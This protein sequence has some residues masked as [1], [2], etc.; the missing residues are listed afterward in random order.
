[1]KG[2][3]ALFA[4]L[5]LLIL[6][7]LAILGMHSGWIPG[8]S[9]RPTDVRIY[10]ETCLLQTLNEGLVTIGQGERGG[11]MLAAPWGNVTFGRTDPA[12]F[13]KL[14]G[15]YIDSNLHECID[16]SDFTAKISAESP[17]TR[18]ILTEG[19]VEAKLSYPVTVVRGNSTE[20]IE[21]YRAKLPFRALYMIETAN[22]IISGR[23]YDMTY[24]D[25]IAANTTIH[26][27]QAGQA[28]VLDDGTWK[29]AFA[30][31]Y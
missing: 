7:A 8:F 3:I 24:L 5:G 20:K 31:K 19:A 14:L 11:E 4:V 29:F 23:H 10:V 12:T 27:Y 30:V 15:E 28:V 13:E 9:Q 1:M 25:S 22:T 21:D 6:V 26:S 2:Q 18:I 17:E 16:F